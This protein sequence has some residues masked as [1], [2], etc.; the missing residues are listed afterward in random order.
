VLCFIVRLYEPLF[1]LCDAF[2]EEGVGQKAS[3]AVTLD[4]SPLSSR[5]SLTPRSNHVCLASVSMDRTIIV[6]AQLARSGQKYTLEEHMDTVHRKNRKFS[7][8]DCGVGFSRR[9]KVAQVRL[10]LLCCCV[11]FGDTIVVV[12]PYCCAH[13]ER[14]LWTQPQGVDSTRSSSARACISG[15]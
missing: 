4:S 5:P 9:H 10:L 11:F 13:Q 14:D 8:T 7:C 12:H 1:S 15:F 2:L 3:D 6:F